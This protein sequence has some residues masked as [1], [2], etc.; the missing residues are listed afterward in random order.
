M[1]D[2]HCWRTRESVFLQRKK[3]TPSIRWWLNNRK[4]RVCVYNRKE[5]NILVFTYVNLIQRAC[6]APPH[7]P[8]INLL[9]LQVFSIHSFLS[10]LAKFF[11]LRNYLYSWINGKE[12]DFLVS[13]CTLNK[14]V[15]ARTVGLL[16]G[17]HVHKYEMVL[18]S[19]VIQKK[20]VDKE[21]EYSSFS[22][23]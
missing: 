1:C 4:D 13:V 22:L 6:T 16:L 19:H 23:L 12:S 2:W 10:S 9:F 8:F 15:I 20:G 3:N 14:G 5:Q 17:T 11:S 21:T 7:S 18:L